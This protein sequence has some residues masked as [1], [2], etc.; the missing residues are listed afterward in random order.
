M[1]DANSAGLGIP[2]TV[3]STD[4]ALRF[5]RNTTVANLQPGQTATLGQ[6]IVGYEINED[7]D[8]GYRPAGLIDMSATTF[9]T[10]VHVRD[11]TG[12]IEGPATTTADITLYR[13][14]RGALVFSAGTVQWAWGLSNNHIDGTG[15]TSDPSMQ[16]ATV[17][18]LADMY[19][20]PQTLQP[21]LMPAAPSI[22]VTPPTSTITSPSSGGSFAVGSTVS[23]SGTA[24]DVGGVMAGRRGLGRRRPDLAP[25]DRAEQLDLHLGRQH[26][27]TN[28]DQ[29]SRRGRQ[30]KHR[31][32]LRGDHRH[33]ATS[34]NQHGGPGGRVQLRRGERDHPDRPLRQRQQRDDHH[35]DLGP[36]HLRQR[37]VL[38]RDQ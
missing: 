5:W 13:A 37:P 11:N 4:S 20:Q 19:A 8:N 21:G 36:R 1:D 27:G 17:N 9:T 38:Q 7:V 6:Y 24:S 26:A 29:V 12:R 35:C 31:D 22:D 2:L 15:N 18:L 34:A 16:Q 14:S 33:G 10:P 25:R 28:H 30:R 32:A 23:I 3:R